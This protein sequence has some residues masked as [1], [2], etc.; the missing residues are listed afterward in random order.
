ME[1]QNI[2]KELLVNRHLV[3]TIRK[4][5]SKSKVFIFHKWQG[6]L[7]MERVSE[8]KSQAIYVQKHSFSNF[9]DLRF[10]F[11]DLISKHKY[12]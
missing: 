7:E 1:F 8:H 2:P 5:V 3:L 12:L 11:K 4:S 6:I 10:F 9:Y